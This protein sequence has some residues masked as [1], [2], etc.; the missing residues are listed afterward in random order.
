M[1]KEKET[2]EISQELNEER[3]LCRIS[4][5][6]FAKEFE[7]SETTVRKYFESGYA[8][9]KIV[10]QMKLLVRIYAVS[11]TE[12][13]NTIGK[14]FHIVF[15]KQILHCLQVLHSRTSVIL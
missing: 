3:N 13:L 6:K 8:P 5:S 10:Q 7:I 9:K 2:I 15:R 4:Y 12:A 1:F 14:R 11:S